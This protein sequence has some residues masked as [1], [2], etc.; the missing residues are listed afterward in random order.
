MPAAQ[1]K[2]LF[3]R[4]MIHLAVA[5]LLGIFVYVPMSMTEISTV[6]NSQLAKNGWTICRSL[7]LP[8]A[9]FV[10]ISSNIEL[11]IA[12]G[13]LC[14]QVRCL[15][16]LRVVDWFLPLVWPLGII[17]GCLCGMLV[18]GYSEEKSNCSLIAGD[19]LDVV[20]SIVFV[21][22][23]VPMLAYVCAVC[24]ACGAPQTV[25]QRVMLRSVMYAL[26][27]LFTYLPLVPYEL[28]PALHKNKY[29]EFSTVLAICSNG[30]LNTLAYAIVVRGTN[31]LTRDGA[32]LRSVSVQAEDD[33]LGFTSFHVAF[34]SE[35][36]SVI[37]PETSEA[38][39]LAEASWR[40]VRAALSP[41]AALE[42]D[43]EDLREE[44]EVDAELKAAKKMRKDEAKAKRAA[45]LVKCDGEKSSQKKAKDDLAKVLMTW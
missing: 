25:A 31:K 6:M 45:E 11:Q 16:L 35:S 4:Q 5:D 2:Q 44:N 41:E 43:L 37:S 9:S 42:R 30:F 19:H 40:E 20:P 27:C 23:C 1:R 33:P 26:S 7:S 15:R 8:F 38:N 13:F 32:T 28:S 22:Q 14:A 18:M 21:G 36:Q 34:G 17:C 39:I 10:A 3:A 29:W 12:L 24:F